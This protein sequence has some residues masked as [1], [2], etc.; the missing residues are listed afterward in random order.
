MHELPSY[1]PCPPPSPPPPPPPSLRGDLGVDLRVLAIATSKQMLLSET[2]IDL[3][4]WE[5][6]FKAEG[7]ATD[8]S[9]LGQHMK[10]RGGG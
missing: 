4:G 6:R 10:V 9:R 5:E 3:D 7:T 1:L 2:P 8:L